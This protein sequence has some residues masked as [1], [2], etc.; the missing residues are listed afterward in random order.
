MSDWALLESVEGLESSSAQPGALWELLQGEK[1]RV[2]G[3]ISGAGK[4]AHGDGFAA[5]ERDPSAE[6]IEVIDWRHRDELE[7]QMR[8]IIDAQDRLMDGSNGRCAECGSEIGV[9][10]LLANP[11][12]T[13]FPVN[14]APSRNLRFTQSKALTLIFERG[15][16]EQWLSAPRLF[17]PS[18]E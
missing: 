3:E 17:F 10:R 11:A 15:G 9:K 6:Y 2:C 7:H 18:I 16:A 14:K 5:N 13:A 1:E 4:L 12:A 8:D